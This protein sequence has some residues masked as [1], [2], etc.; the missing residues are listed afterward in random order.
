[1]KNF[2][3]V[4]ID[5]VSHAISS[6]FKRAENKGDNEHESLRYEDFLQFKM[7]YESFK[8]VA[9]ENINMIGIEAQELKNLEKDREVF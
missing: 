9:N 8:E 5:K 4:E 3:Q 7:V 1:M 6:F 2:E